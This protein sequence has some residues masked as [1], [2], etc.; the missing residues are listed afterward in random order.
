M[1]SLLSRRFSWFQR[2]SPGSSAGRPHPL[3][4]TWDGRGTNFALVSASAERVELC[5]FDRYGRH[6]TRRVALPERTEDVWHGYFHDVAPG[7]LYGYRVHGPFAPDRGLRFNAHKLLID[8]YAKALAGETAETPA[9]A[10][11]RW[12][13]SSL[14]VIGALLGAVGSLVAGLFATGHEAKAGSFFGAGA[15]LLTAAL[16]L[17]WRSFQRTHAAGPLQPSLTR[18]GM[19]NAGRHPVRSVLTMGLLAFA[20]FLIVAARLRALPASNT[21]N[22]SHFCTTKNSRAPMIPAINMTNASE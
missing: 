1:S 18:L 10:R 16:A 15:L 5:L 13:W 9:V 6:E 19:R 21:A 11:A 4:A 12:R 3:G 7:Q 14:V 22:S 20:T 8:P 17:A 2:A